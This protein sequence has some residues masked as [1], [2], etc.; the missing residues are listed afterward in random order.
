MFCEKKVVVTEVQLQKVLKPAAPSWKPAGSAGS[1]CTDSPESSDEGAAVEVIRSV[2][3][4]HVTPHHE[5]STSSGEDGTLENGAGSDAHVCVVSSAPQVS[6]SESGTATVTSTVVLPMS[7][8]SSKPSAAL[9]GWGLLPPVEEADAESS[10]QEPETDKVKPEV[11]QS[12]PEV[13]DSD[14]ESTSGATHKR[15]KPFQGGVEI[16]IEVENNHN[17]DDDK[18]PGN[19]SEKLEDED[20]STEVNDEILN[21]A[22]EVITENDDLLTAL[23]KLEFHV[24]GGT[25]PLKEDKHESSHNEQEKKEQAVSDS[26][27]E[28]GSKEAKGDKVV[29]IVRKRNTASEEQKDEFGFV[30]PP[31]ENK[32]T[33]DTKLPKTKKTVTKGEEANKTK[34]T[35]QKEGNRLIRALNWVSKLPARISADKQTKRQEHKSEKPAEKQHAKSEE[36]EE[37]PKEKEEVVKKESD[38][39][40]Y[41]FA[42]KLNPRS[43]SERQHRTQQKLSCQKG[44]EEPEVRR[45]TPEPPEPKSEPISRREIRKYETTGEI[46]TEVLSSFQPDVE[47]SHFREN[48]RRFDNV[49]L[50]KDKQTPR[51]EPDESEREKRGPDVEEPAGDDDD[52][53][54]GPRQTGSLPNLAGAFLS[55]SPTV[56]RIREYM[57]QDESDDSS[58]DEFLLIPMPTDYEETVAAA[59]ATTPTPAG[60]P[61]PAPAAPCSPHHANPYQTQLDC[62]DGYDAQ[63]DTCETEAITPQSRCPDSSAATPCAESDV[64]G[65]AASSPPTSTEMAKTSASAEIPPEVCGDSVSGCGPRPVQNKPP[66]S[67]TGS[68]RTRPGSAEAAVPPSAGAGAP[69]PGG[70]APAHG[71]RPVSIPRAIRGAHSPYTPPRSS[72]SAPSID[73]AIPRRT[74]PPGIPSPRRGAGLA[75][76]RGPRQPGADSTA[77]RSKAKPG[78]GAQGARQ[79]GAAASPAAVRAVRT[80]AP[81]PRLTQQPGT[82][83]RSSSMGFHQ[84]PQYYIASHKPTNVHTVNSR[85]I[86]KGALSGRGAVGGGGGGGGSGR[87][88]PGHRAPGPAAAA[89]AAAPRNEANS[90][91]VGGRGARNSTPVLETDLDQSEPRQ[92][93]YSAG[94]RSAVQRVQAR[95]TL[96]QSPGPANT[97]SAGIPRQGRGNTSLSLSGHTHTTPIHTQSTIAHVQAY[98]PR[99]Q[100]RRPLVQHVD[101]NGNDLQDGGGSSNWMDSGVQMDFTDE[102]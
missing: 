56:E 79:P 91:S 72:R 60:G 47:D 12:P 23:D 2:Q 102:G 7:L 75:G 37:K 82:A 4:K 41:G 58:L 51:K 62:G 93:R 88:R 80:T 36:K 71:S 28:S 97:A 100:P 66:V 9:P 70:P 96:Q 94:E 76:H 101:G 61:A 77:D 73:R 54:P 81:C 15:L 85:P 33:A 19:K 13:S 86:H 89:A 98:S 43:L 68:S 49:S 21:R 25:D 84:Q 5:T 67:S 8:G 16:A 40:D 1:D 95:I 29:E 57:L 45:E 3:F 38:D 31:T 87:P 46:V 34:G 53:E 26:T 10:E 48:L 59:A 17:H 11:I 39:E 63:S 90:N 32:E 24:N 30:I 22:Y 64:C 27:K 83:A 42:S 69:A 52:W 35:K 78:P 74:A 18:L 20:F 55:T 50:A 99:S 65:D 14:E 6:F 92:V 44:E